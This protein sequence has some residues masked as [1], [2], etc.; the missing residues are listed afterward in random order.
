MNRFISATAIALI[1]ATPAYAKGPQK[2][3]PLADSMRSYNANQSAQADKA[4]AE[5]AALNTK[6]TQQH[7]K[8]LQDMGPVGTSADPHSEQLGWTFGMSTDNVRRWMVNLMAV[9]PTALEWLVGVMAVKICLTVRKVNREEEEQ[10]RRDAEQANAW[11]S[12]RAGATRLEPS[13]GGSKPAGALPAPEKTTAREPLMLENGNAGETETEAAVIPEAGQAGYDPFYPVSE[14][15]GD[16]AKAGAAAVK[17]GAG[18]ARKAVAEKTA[19]YRTPHRVAADAPDIEQIKGLR[20]VLKITQK[21]LAER[22]G[23][24]ESAVAKWEQGHRIPDE[25]EFIAKLNELREKA[26][27]ILSGATARASVA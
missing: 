22:I 10:A 14:R 21:E 3:D 8:A 17:V 12:T 18:R 19:A 13:F 1:L 4:R 11:G 15:I 9:L 6:T 23:S 25:P 5:A 24:S 27:S 7:I 16:A 26:R 2:P 20:K